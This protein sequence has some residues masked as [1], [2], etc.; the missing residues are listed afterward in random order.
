[1][2]FGFREE[3]PLIRSAIYEATILRND[4]V[5]FLAAASN[6]GGNSRE[7]FPAS[8]DAVIS[9]RATNAHGAFLDT[10]PPADPY[11]PAVYGTLGKDVPAAW[12]SSVNGELSKSGSSVATAIAAGIAAM[13]LSVA[14]AGFESEQFRM[15][16][17]VEG[18]WTKKGME[19]LFRKMAQDMGG[20]C[21]Y[22]SPGRFFEEKDIAQVWAAMVDACS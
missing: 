20:R 5:L 19:S 16:Q 10:N 18:L 1:M 7:L 9:V 22:I 6:Y 4:R 3:I 15:P 17:Q 11:G 8:H 13:M 2:S 14:N 21:F 12:L